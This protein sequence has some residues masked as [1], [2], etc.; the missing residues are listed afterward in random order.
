MPK[1]PPFRSPPRVNP[2]G[3]PRIELRRFVRAI[4]LRTARRVVLPWPAL[5]A[6]VIALTATCAATNDGAP[7]YSPLPPWAAVYDLTTA[8]SVATG[9]NESYEPVIFHTPGANRPSEPNS[10]M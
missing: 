4:S 2:T 9:K 7:K 6:L 10:L 1:P 5:H 3:R 8:L